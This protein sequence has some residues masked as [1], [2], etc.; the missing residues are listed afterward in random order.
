MDFSEAMERPKRAVTDN[1][2]RGGNGRFHQ[3]DPPGHALIRLRGVIV[4]PLEDR[5]PSW[6]DWLANA[7][8]IC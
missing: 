6:R 1:G 4:Q 8:K 7:Q 3:Y 2:D 5:H